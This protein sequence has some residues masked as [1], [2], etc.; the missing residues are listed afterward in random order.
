M[1]L[2]ALHSRGIAI[3]CT[4]SAGEAAASMAAP[5]RAA[6][7]PLRSAA[8]GVGRFVLGGAAFRLPPP[9]G[10]SSLVTNS[11]AGLGDRA[12]SSS[13]TTSVTSPALS[14]S[15]TAPAGA[16]QT[17]R[18]KQQGRPR[19]RVGSFAHGQA[20]FD[21]GAVFRVLTTHVEPYY[22]MPWSTSPQTT[23]SASAFALQDSSGARFLVTNAHAVHH[24]SLVELQRPGED[25]KFL[26]RVI[27]QGPECDLA[28]LEVEPDAA[29]AFWEGVHPWRLGSTIPSLNDRVRVCGYPV[30]G[31]NASVTE[32]VV[33]R[34]EMQPYRHGLG[35]LLAIQIDAAINPGNSGGPVWDS[36]RRCVGVAFQSLKDGDTENIGYVIPAEVVE[37]FI[38]GFRRTGRYA[39]FGHHGFA[40]QPLDN[41]ALQ[42]AF[43]A[44]GGVLVKRI[45]PTAPASRLLQERDILLSIGGHAIGG[46]GTVHF[47]RRERIAFPY[48]TS[49]LCP[50]DGVGV[51][52]LRAGNIHEWTLE[53]TWPL[54]LVPMHPLQPPAYIVYAGLV[55][56]PLSEP[57]LRSEWGE[58]FEER[59]PVSLVE[60]WFKNVRRFE[61]EEVVVLSCVFASPLTAGL[62]HFA[63]RRLLRV[64]GRDVKNLLHL[65]DL[66]DQPHGAVMFFELDDNDIIALPREAAME[67][68]LAVLRAHFIPAERSLPREVMLRE[69][70]TE[71]SAF[72][73]GP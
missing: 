70:M 20:E 42:D 72:D 5:A 7:R 2:G 52:V 13:S 9:P 12:V 16:R 71:S 36:R 33:S 73:A 43:G 6:V 67:T 57:Y 39:G 3:G 32:G 28:L 56:V 37:H 11:L 17:W 51:K 65:A 18:I 62:T 49:R 29:D 55:F 40:W 45:E 48:V 38:A 54:P 58:L 35:S 22:T 4:A 34:V 15:P 64:D 53:L 59:A 61:G 41:R 47:R 63:N 26:A 8:P 19:L 60:P 31:E 14:V 30:G 44:E 27:C 1:P 24:A 46:G 10:F 25:A 68:T 69:T 50:G 23:S 21:P 66:L